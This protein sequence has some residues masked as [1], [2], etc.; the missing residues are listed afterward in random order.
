M[1]KIL[2]AE[3]EDLLR[4]ILEEELVD[5][6]FEVVVAANGR[7]TLDLA[8]RAEPDLILS[9]YSMPDMDGAQMVAALQDGGAGLATIPVIMLSAISDRATELKLRSAGAIN[10]LR[11]PCDFKILIAAIRSQLALRDSIH[12]HYRRKVDAF[13]AL[14]GKE[15]GDEEKDEFLNDLSQRHER[16]VRLLRLPRRITPF[17][18]EARFRFRTPEEASSVAVILSYCFEDPEL[19]GVGLVE[20]FYN[21]IEHGNLEVDFNRKT[22]LLEKGKWHEEIEKLLSDNRFSNRFVTV[23]FAKKE[24]EIILSVEDEGQGFDWQSYLSQ[25]L[26]SDPSRHGRGIAI[27]ANMSFDSLIYNNKGNRVT[28]R[29]PMPDS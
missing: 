2:I 14:H 10:F 11:K 8:R 21:A 25:D 9:D 18:D 29:E 22:E 20:L 13:F 17:L 5:N 3:D 23:D 26:S 19:A 6:G 28:V 1:T 15:G 7:E 4:E 12:E 27:A 24:N 16:F